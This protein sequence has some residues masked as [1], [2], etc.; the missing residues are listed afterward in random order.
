M[1]TSI[2]CLKCSIAGRQPG[3]RQTGSALRALRRRIRPLTLDRARLEA[4]TLIAHY[5][6]SPQHT[7]KSITLIPSWR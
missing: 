6:H 7:V 2:W 5:Q 1:A 3:D 4:Q